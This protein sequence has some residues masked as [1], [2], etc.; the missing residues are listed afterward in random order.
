[1]KTSRW[2]LLS[3]VLILLVSGC[4]TVKLAQS[5]LEVTAPDDQGIVIGTIT[6]NYGLVPYWGSLLLERLPEQNIELDSVKSAKENKRKPKEDLYR[7]N[8][9]VASSGMYTA[10]YSGIVPPGKY[11]IHSVESSTG[12]GQYWVNFKSRNKDVIEVKPGLIV[13][14]GR[15]IVTG[16]P[17]E[18]R[19]ILANS[20][21]HQ[22]NQDFVDR[23]APYLFDTYAD[24]EWS[25]WNSGVSDF[26]L[27]LENFAINHAY[28]FYGITVDDDVVYAG[29]RMGVVHTFNFE[30][31][32]YDII[33]TNALASITGFRSTPDYLYIGGQMSFLAELNKKTGVIKD[34][35]TENLPSGNIAFIY[36]PEEDEIMI[37]LIDANHISFYRCEL[38]SSCRWRKDKQYPITSE[39]MWVGRIAGGIST[40]DDGFYVFPGEERLVRYDRRTN[41]WIEKQLP[42]VTFSRRAS[43]NGYLSIQTPGMP[44]KNYVS[45]DY[46][47]S[48]ELIEYDDWVKS[49]VIFKD[50]DT[51]Y[52]MTSPSLLGQEFWL[53]RSDDGGKTWAETGEPLPFYG[54]QEFVYVPEREW[55]LLTTPALYRSSVL[56]SY[57]IETGSSF[58]LKSS[59]PKE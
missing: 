12:V 2:T 11:R 54:P 53:S 23:Y 36:K 7:L 33:R 46:G 43:D 58:T 9:N 48:W 56:M 15:L 19:V 16:T 57:E 32:S 18:D 52:M 25:V 40:Y 22:D 17:K 35:D 34:I 38:S 55:L 5:P 50:E 28:G 49:P 45:K 21:R 8:T 10:L 6:H 1:M 51:A 59:K 42:R 44:Y 27:W 39:N 37:A 14:I 47:D 24:R 3:V 29:S 41:E 13:D 4:S 20:Y 26:E 31:K 30:T